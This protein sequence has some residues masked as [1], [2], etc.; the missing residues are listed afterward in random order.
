[1]YGS[2][3]LILTAYENHRTDT[4]YE[5]ALISKTFLFKFVNSYN[6]LFYI[7][8]VKRF[9]NDVG[10]CV[11]QNCNR[12]LQQQLAT[13]FIANIVISNTVEVVIPTLLKW[14]T[15]R[16]NAVKPGDGVEVKKKTDAEEQFELAP[17]DGTFN[18]FDELVIQFGYVTLFVVAFPLAP[19]AALLNNIVE[20]RVDATKLIKL[21]RRPEPRGA[22][23]I[24]TWYSV[25]D[26]MS[27][28]A[29]GTNCAIICFE[30]DLVN[31]LVSR[32][33]IKVY[34]F[35]IAE[36]LILLMKFA[37][38]YFVPDTPDGLVTH[39]ARQEYIVNVLING[40]EEEPEDD[41]DVLKEMKNGIASTV[42]NPDFDWKRVK[43]NPSNDGRHEF[44]RND[45]S[46]TFGEDAALSPRI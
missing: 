5:N 15:A 33:A 16:Q 18:D 42:E 30:T 6:S 29:V 28:I 4:E 39:L 20:T 31:D 23:N 43:E 26:I 13:I 38:A 25:L 27:I 21:T 1:M 40:M 44:F 41:V 11:Q 35:I 22:A 10:G 46:R 9:D 3:S 12:E 17:Y 8:F 36:H 24:G 2:V 7:A 32:E 19:L 34:V 37:L 45:R 14:H